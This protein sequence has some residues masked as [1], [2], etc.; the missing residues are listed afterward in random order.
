MVQKNVTLSLDE[1][2]YEKYKEFCKKNAV[3]LSRSIDVFMEEK[4]KKEEK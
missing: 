3:A 4:I 1:D 2:T